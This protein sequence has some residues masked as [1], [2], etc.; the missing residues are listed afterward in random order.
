MSMFAL[1]TSVRVLRQTKREVEGRG[2]MATKRNNS[3]GE[4][5]RVGWDATGSGQVVL[6]AGSV[7]RDALLIILRWL[8][9]VSPLLQPMP[10]ANVPS[11]SSSIHPTAENNERQQQQKRLRRHK[12][13]PALQ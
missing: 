2:G 6:H 1:P 9:F 4:V 5:V 3:G 12:K 10:C 7:S 13:K 8:S 11:C